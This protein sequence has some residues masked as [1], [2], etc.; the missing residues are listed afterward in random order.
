MAR[1][2]TEQQSKFI[3]ALLGEAK[4]NPARAKQLAGYLPGT[5]TK[6]LVSSLKDEILEATRLYLALHAPSAA[7]GIVDA[8]S[9][10]TELGIKEKLSAAKDLL[11]RIGIVKTEKV[12]VES[13]GGV[14][15]LPPKQQNADEQ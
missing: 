6:D 12:Q 13:S 11:D 4:G 7:I 10:P 9:D 5:N 15:L 2:L 8:I 1:Q 14:M 3:D